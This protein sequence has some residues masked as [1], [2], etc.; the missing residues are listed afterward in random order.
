LNKEKTLK[1]IN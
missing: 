1:K